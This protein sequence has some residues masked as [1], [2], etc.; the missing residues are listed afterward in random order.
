MKLDSYIKRLT[1]LRQELG[2]VEVMHRMPNDSDLEGAQFPVIREVIVN[3][4]ERWR[5]A[6]N[7]DPE[8]IIVKV[9]ELF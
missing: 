1:K 2:N 3:G 8:K 7:R 6:E 4:M 9:I 5:I